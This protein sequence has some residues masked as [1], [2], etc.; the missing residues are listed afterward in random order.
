[1]ELLTATTYPLSS[2]KYAIQCAVTTSAVLA[3]S[4][5]GGLTFQDITGVSYTDDADG[6][7]DLPTCI[8]KPTLV[9]ATMFLNKK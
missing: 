3:M 6:I 2:G 4:L 7:L 1:M 8:V 5:D 9:S